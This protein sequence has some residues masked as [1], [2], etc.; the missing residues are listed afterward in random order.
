VATTGAIYKETASVLKMAAG[1]SFGVKVVNSQHEFE[2]EL[3][4]AGDRAVIIDFYATW[5]GPCKNIA[6]RI[7]DMAKKYPKVVVLKADVDVAED[8]AEKYNI[9]CLPTFKVFIGGREVTGDA[10]STANVV[11]VE[12]LFKKYG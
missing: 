10:I 3:R 12:K 7:G 4:A 9:E 6:P 11:A 2:R 5:C 1:G 8:L